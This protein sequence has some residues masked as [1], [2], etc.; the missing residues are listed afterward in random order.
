M[1]ALLK[2]IKRYIADMLSL[3]QMSERFHLLSVNYLFVML[4]YTLETVFVNTLLYRVNPDI[5]IV[6][7]YR[8]CVYAMT[9]VSM[10]LAAYLAN[11][12]SPVMVLKLGGAFYALMYVVLFFGM[13]RMQVM[14]YPVAALSGLGAGFYWSGH[15][16]LLTHFTTRQNRN[17]GVAVMGI[18]QGVMTLLLPVV[19]GFVIECMPG[20]AGYR[21]MFGL[22]ML[23]VFS[24]TYFMNRLGRVERKAPVSNFSLALKLI[25]R[26]A[27]CKLMLG[28]EFTRGLRDGALLFYLNMLLFQIVEQESLVGINT[29][30]TGALSIFGSWV[31]G[32]LAVPH[33][34]ARYAFASTAVLLALCA[35]LLRWLGVWSVMLFACVNAFFQIFITYSC[36]SYAYDVV[37]Q[38]D[39]TRQAMAELLAFRELALDGGRVVGLLCVLLFPRS[40]EGQVQAMC[41]LTAAQIFTSALLSLTQHV[42]NR[43]KRR[44]GEAAANV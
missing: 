25:W 24:Q 17:V 34:R 19:S 29:F 10:N 6:I 12:R 33:M 21:V 38:N 15:H 13:D 42:L 32:R 41:V 20:S 7:F 14:M 2:G 26:K 5:S 35:M 40:P 27:S 28:F 3:E 11:T 4:Y 9:A 23:T 39:T 16:L 18:I 43:K 1:K 8:V 30:L 22:G 36:N 37:A 31:Y 44:R